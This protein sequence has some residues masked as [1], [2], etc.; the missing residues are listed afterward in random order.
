MMRSLYFL[1][2]TVTKYRLIAHTTLQESNRLLPIVRDN[3]SLTR[4]YNDFVSLIML[5]KSLDPPSFQYNLPSNCDDSLYELLR[6]EECILISM[7][8][9]CRLIRQKVVNEKMIITT[10]KDK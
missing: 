10:R 9:I 3:Y 4:I 2:N 7:L 6:V 1:D 5:V 8:K